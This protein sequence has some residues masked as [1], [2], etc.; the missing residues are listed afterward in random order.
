MRKLTA[1]E[2]LSQVRTI[3]IEINTKLHEIEELKQR[4]L[5]VQSGTVSE[6]V[7]CSNDNS[8]NKIIDKIIDLESLINREID[9]LVD[10]KA[11]IHSR[12]MQL[13][14]SRYR[15][16]LIEHYINGRTLEHIAESM[17]CSDRHV[18]RLHAHALQVFQKNLI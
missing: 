5:C 16:L 6:R 17:K 10:L 18:R 14:D 7:Q 12:I 15:I 11:E 3:D 8:A 13:N 1:K 9:K 2:Y 4:S